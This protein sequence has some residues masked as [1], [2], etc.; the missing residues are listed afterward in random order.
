MAEEKISEE[1][2][3]EE[4]GK[5][6]E[7]GEETSEDE[8]GEGGESP[9]K[10]KKMMIIIIIIILLIGGGG[11]GAYL[12]GF[13]PGVGGGGDEEVDPN[14]IPEI[15]Y[16]D[17]KEFLV[18]LN[19]P[20]EKVS[21]LK[22]TITLELPDNASKLT[23]EAKMPRIRDSFQVYLRELRNSDLRGSAGT[24]RLREEL[25]FRINKIMEPE[26]VSDILFKEILVQ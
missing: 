17:L 5:K 7:E 18:N 26:K 13:I 11:A 14:K 4:G 15:V 19:N 6:K 20:R 2:K 23:A 9:K 16:Y 8:D 22:M 10:K 25:L 24:H 12:G 3:L 1:E 21:F